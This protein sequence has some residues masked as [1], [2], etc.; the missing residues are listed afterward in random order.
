MQRLIVA[1][2]KRKKTRSSGIMYQLKMKR[3]TRRKNARTLKRGK[4][5]RTLKRGKKMRT[6]KRG[7]KR[8]TLRTILLSKASALRKRLLS[9][10][11]GHRAYHFPRSEVWHRETAREGGRLGVGGAGRL[12]KA[13][14]GRLPRPI[15]SI[16]LSRSPGC[17]GAG[18][19]A[20]R[21][22]GGERDG[23]GSS[24]ESRR[25]PPLAAS[26]C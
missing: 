15:V 20:G 13:A 18:G 14:H 5:R 22:R 24:V 7:R 12:P 16:F 8:M 3:R 25:L 2:L 11:L 17:W 26:P 19:K 4:K 9:K 1:R 10:P 23:E 6:L 21:R